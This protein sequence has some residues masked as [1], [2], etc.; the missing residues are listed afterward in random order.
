V[1]CAAPPDSQNSGSIYVCGDW[2]SSAALHRVLDQH[3]KVRNR[4][5]WE[6][7][8]GRGAQR[9]WKMRAEDIWFYTVS[10]RLF[11]DVEAVKLK[12]RV[13]A[14]YKINGAPKDGRKK[15]AAFV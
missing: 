8:K 12:R 3:V 7:E 11:F 9:N 1:V 14:P 15:K 13:I 10:G 4:I 6:R 5:T 2:K